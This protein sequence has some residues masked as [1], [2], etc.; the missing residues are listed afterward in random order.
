MPRVKIDIRRGRSEQH[1]R[2]LLDEVHSALVEALEIPEDDRI[3][4]LYEHDDLSFEI[5]PYKTGM[6]TLIEITMFSGRSLDAKRTLYK[7]IT[8]NVKRLG[9]EE[10]DT[11]IILLEPAMENWGLR[12]K[13]ASELEI[14]FKIDV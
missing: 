1:K 7:T 12:G 11:M 9:I 14:D 5:P 6:F 13:P 3:Q 10:Y 2:E 8:R 4:T